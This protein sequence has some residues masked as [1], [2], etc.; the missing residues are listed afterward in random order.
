MSRIVTPAWIF[1]R[2]FSTSSAWKDRIGDWIVSAHDRHETLKRASPRTAV[3]YRSIVE[4]SAATAPRTCEPGLSES[5]AGSGP[6][7]C[8]SA[9]DVAATSASVN[10]TSRIKRFSR[11]VGVAPIAGGHTT[12]PMIGV[13]VRFPRRNADTSI[14]MVRV[15]RR[16]R[17]SFRRRAPSVVRVDCAHT[18]RIQ[19]G[20]SMGNPRAYRLAE[21]PKKVRSARRSI[22]ALM[23]TMIDDAD[24]SRAEISGRSDQPHSG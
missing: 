11:W 6:G 1:D 22:T 10:K 24:M 17:P 16:R 20:Q 19:E 15:L 8:A 21:L 5:S 7:D 2:R 12:T 23:A 9:T 13:L 18:S 3:R 4:L 14:R